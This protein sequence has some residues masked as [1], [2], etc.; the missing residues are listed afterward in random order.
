MKIGAIGYNY[1]H[2]NGF[3]MER[4]NGTGCGL[5][6]IIKEPSLFLINSTE[7]R[8]K[9]NSFVI[10]SP[11]TAYRY[12]GEG[13]VYAD[14]WI[15]FDFTTELS[16]K[17]RELNIPTDEIIHLGNSDELSQI[18][19]F[20]TYEHYSAEPGHDEIE[21]M[22]FEILLR[23]LGRLVASGAKYSQA[24]ADKNNRFVQLRNR[25]YS[26]PEEIPDISR[27]AQE[28]GM[29]RSGFQHKYKRVFGVS[30][31]TDIINARMEY[32]KNLL[33]STDLP[34]AKIAGKCGYS[35]EYSFMR[36]FKSRFGKTPT[37]FRSII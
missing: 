28:F 27:L 4:P 25:L 37:Q 29:S 26:M 2:R 5:L 23:K 30:T 36:Q 13:D 14:D 16:E 31:R 22:Y 1:R 15:Y 34:I 24:V 33:I 17:L 11:T 18:V 12:C 3:V 6:L 7:H 20:M 9:K 8:V 10:F 35:S 19:H 32:A 21:L